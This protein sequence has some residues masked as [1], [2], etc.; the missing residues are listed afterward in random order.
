MSGM[1]QLAS[2]ALL[3]VWIISCG[4]AE[5]RG[6]IAKRSD[7][8]DRPAYQDGLA[9]VLRSLPDD[10]T[11]SGVD[12]VRYTYDL[13]YHVG[14]FERMQDSEEMRRL[15]VGRGCM[16]ALDAFP[17]ASQEQAEQ[18]TVKCMDL[19]REAMKIKG[20][21]RG[22]QYSKAKLVVAEKGVEAGDRRIAEILNGV[23]DVGYGKGFSAGAMPDVFQAGKMGCQVIAER[24]R[25][26]GGVKCS[27]IG[28]ALQ[29][30]YLDSLGR[31]SESR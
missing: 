4:G 27:E 24:R 31:F 15:M 19:T 3:S 12:W 7:L 21:S 18:D 28:A 13:G 5:T 17:S 8:M 30:E 9:D 11:Q 10:I 20:G 6:P 16:A 2:V 22:P 14:D 1:Y 26:E 25:V 29:K 23:F